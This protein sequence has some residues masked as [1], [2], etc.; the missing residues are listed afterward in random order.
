MQVSLK[1]DN[2]NIFCMKTIFK[3]MVSRA[4]LRMT[5]VAVQNIKTCFTFIT[6]FESCVVYDT[7]KNT[8]EP[9]SPDD[10]VI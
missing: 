5:N 10:D 8:V 6:F 7:W 1:A 9:D 4:N 3:S 2:N